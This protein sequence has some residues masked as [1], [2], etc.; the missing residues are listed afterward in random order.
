MIQ[1]VRFEHFRCL[2]D[3]E[4]S[5]EPLTVLVGPPASGKT[6]VLEAL[7]LLLGCDVS[8]FWRQDASRTP[9]VEWRYDNGKQQRV[10]YPVTSLDST[11]MLMHSVQALALDVVALRAESSTGR[12]PALNRTGD[13]LAGVF[14]SLQ[15]GQRQQVIHELCRLVP[16]LRDVRIHLSSPRTQRL[17]F[18]DWWKT[19]LWLGADKVADTAMMLLAYLVL[20]YQSPPPDVLTL[21]MPE[22]GLPPQLLS[23]LMKL[24]RGL[25]TGELGGSPIQVVMATSSTGLLRHVDSREIRVLSR[26]PDDGA[27]QVSTSPADVADWRQRLEMA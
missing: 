26:S 15:A 14:A 18:L 1:S 17:Q 27:V 16:A 7:D 2:R 8:D 12:W 19:D 6:T 4:L 3:V 25:T 23:E 13:N 11:P 5:L 20:P 22:R 21:D 10:E 9:V 24:L